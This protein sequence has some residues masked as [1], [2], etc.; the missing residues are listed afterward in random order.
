MNLDIQANVPLATFTTLEIGG[1]AR[2]FIDVATELQLSEAV[3][4]AYDNE[5]D[6]F[7]LG[8]GSNVLI[9]DSGFDGL[10]IKISI[11]GITFEDEICVANAGEDWD[12][13]VKACVENDLQGLECLSGIP[14]LVGGTPIQ[15]VG[16]YGQEVSQTIEM[17]RVFDCK[18]LQFLEL[19]NSDC[20]FSYRKSIF[21]SSE[22]NRFI[23]VSVKFKLSKNGKPSIIYKDLM[24]FFDQRNPT[25]SETRD[26]VC[27]IRSK[28]AMLVRQGLQDSKSVGSFFK[29][30][31]VSN[32]VFEK[33]QTNLKLLVPKFAV[34]DENVKIPAAWLIEQAGF[35]KGYQH[36]NAGLSTRHTLALINRDN[37]SASDILDLKA[38]IQAK[39][40][41][42]FGIELH[43]EPI[44]V[45]F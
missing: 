9:A 32:V 25:L 37:A 27:L 43:A 19:Q 35:Q 10:V 22:T 17:V 18:S 15:N 36:G 29:N 40:E 14:G 28:K 20:K 1:N 45:G 2:L 5:I 44:F 11:K 41:L 6:I 24:D 34:D 38:E 42:K 3:K 23:V 16:A 8:G 26:A 21:N 31:I 13:L 7:V 30:P 12:E 33:L 4:F 39:V